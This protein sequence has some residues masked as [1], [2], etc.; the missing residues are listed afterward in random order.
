MISKIPYMFKAVLKKR[1]PSKISWDSEYPRSSRHHSNIQ[2][3]LKSAWKNRS[4][5][6]KHGSVPHLHY[7]TTDNEPNSNGEPAK[8]IA[9]SSLSDSRSPRSMDFGRSPMQSRLSVVTSPQKLTQRKI[10]G[11]QHK[12][13]R[14][15]ENECGFQPFLPQNMNVFLYLELDR[16]TDQVSFAEIGSIRL[17]LWD[18][19]YVKLIQISTTA[20]AKGEIKI[21][22]TW[23]KE[24][25]IWKG[26]NVD[27]MPISLP[28][29]GR[30]FLGFEVWS[31]YAL[32]GLDGWMDYSNAYCCDQELTMFDEIDEILTID[33]II[34]TL[35]TPYFWNET[36]SNVHTYKTHLWKIIM[37][38]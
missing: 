35:R 6:R 19:D 32:N 13:G 21:W 31:V 24:E 4:T 27:M 29:T 2:F 17:R 20:K 18:R 9:P 7:Q 16:I 22:K 33:N 34:E 11:F 25:V 26:T 1:W 37:I 36:V 38:E 15:S 12:I 5:K 28:N 3:L 14:H 23:K 30:P 8:F 10:A